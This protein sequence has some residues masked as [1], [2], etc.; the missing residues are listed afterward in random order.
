MVTGEEVKVAR[1]A[2][3]MTQVQ[4]GQWLY[5]SERQVR[6]WESGQIEIPS[7]AWEKVQNTIRMEQANGLERTIP[8]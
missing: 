2:L 3:D 7:L 5:V 8:A 4:F 1:K 6:N